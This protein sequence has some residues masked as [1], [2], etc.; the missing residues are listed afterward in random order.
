MPR[1]LKTCATEAPPAPISAEMLDQFVRQGPLTPE[2]LDATVRRFKKAIIERA[3]VAELS[4]HLGYLPLLAL[5]L[6]TRRYVTETPCLI[7]RGYVRDNP[8]IRPI[9]DTT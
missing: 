4:H 7:R 5:C 6:I 1:K 9:G 8:L 2:E 3:L